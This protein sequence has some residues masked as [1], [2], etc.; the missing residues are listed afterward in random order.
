MV[1]ENELLVDLDAVIVFGFLGTFTLGALYFYFAWFLGFGPYA[2]HNVGLTIIL[3]GLITLLIIMLLAKKK[4]NKIPCKRLVLAI[5]LSLAIFTP[6]IHETYL[7]ALKQDQQFEQQVEML[8]PL[9][10]QCLA[11]FSEEQVLFADDIKLYR[12]CFSKVSLK[13]AIKDVPCPRG[14]FQ[15]S[16]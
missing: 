14:S 10:E 15:A 6:I 5:L 3:S 4:E 11:K 7:W 12:Y 2:T 16:I 9:Y 13:S 8:T 1:K